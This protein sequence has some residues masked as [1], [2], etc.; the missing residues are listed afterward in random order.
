MRNNYEIGRG[1]EASP[2]AD[3][4]N[5]IFACFQYFGM[6]LNI[7]LSSVLDHYSSFV[8]SRSP[9]SGMTLFSLMVSNICVSI[10]CMMPLMESSSAFA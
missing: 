5:T 7:L 9:S 3:E 1:A 8:G 2:C 6:V 4:S 10:F